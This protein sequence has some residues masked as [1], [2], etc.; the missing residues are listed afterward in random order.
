MSVASSLESGREG[1]TQPLER[2]EHPPLRL[3]IREG[4]LPDLLRQMLCRGGVH[5]R[6]ARPQLRPPGQLRPLRQL[7]LL[8]TRHLVLLGFLR[9]IAALA[10][11]PAPSWP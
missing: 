10:R 9:T 6:E 3:R 7:P 1:D 8:L 4:C 11:G 2:L 5:R